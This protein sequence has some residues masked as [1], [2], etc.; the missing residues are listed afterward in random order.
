MGL[1]R[2]SGHWQFFIWW[3]IGSAVGWMV[4]MLVFPS[5]IVVFVIRELGWASLSI[6]LAGIGIVTG[7]LT[8]AVQS[9]ALRTWTKKPRRWVFATTLGMI[10]GWEVAYPLTFFALAPSSNSLEENAVR[11][12]VLGA[13]IGIAVGIAQWSVLRERIHHAALW[14]LVS[15][16]AWSS[17]LALSIAAA[18][19]MS[20]L[21]LAPIAPMA[22]EMLQ[23]TV[24][25]TITGTLVGAIGGVVTGIVLLL[26][27]SNMHPVPQSADGWA[28]HALQSL[29]NST[30]RS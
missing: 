2:K 25:F 29:V 9:I 23:L 7:V 10:V 13:T 20:L 15:P 12:A 30:E 27:R 16:L 4:G 22:D 18:N 19:P 26:Q 28:Q 6:G 24:T 11:G 3:V 17:G 5:M 21:L 14:L 1:N 8:G